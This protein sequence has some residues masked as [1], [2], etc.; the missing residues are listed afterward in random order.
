MRKM[1]KSSSRPIPQR[2]CLACRRTAGKRELIRLVR[3]PAGR[4]SVDPSGRHPGRG[5]YLCPEDK[6]WEIG[7]AGGRVEYALKTRLNEKDRERLKAE[8]LGALGEA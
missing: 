3:A 2:T 7:L 6:C 1:E 4:V 5:A 8:G